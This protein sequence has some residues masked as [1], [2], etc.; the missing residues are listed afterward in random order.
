M[1]RSYAALAIVLIALIVGASAYGTYTLFYSSSPTPS[2]SPSPTPTASPQS[3]PTSS[4]TSTPTASPSASPTATATPSSTPTQTSTSPSP[5]NSPTPI[6]TT[7]PTST[8]TPTAEP[9]KTIVVTDVT[10]TQ[11]T[12]TLPVNRIVSLTS[13]LTELLCALGCEDKVVGRDSYSTFPPTVTQVPVVGDSSSDPNIELLLELEPDVVFADTML[14]YNPEAKAAIENAGVPV[15]LE[16][17]NNVTCLENCIQTLGEVLEKEATATEIIDFVTYY[18]N[19]VG[20]R[21]ENVT[22]SEKPAVYIEWGEWQSY[23]EGSGAHGNIVAAGGSNIA[24]GSASGYPTLSPEY[25]VEKNPDVILLLEFGASEKNMTSYQTSINTFLDRG[26]LDDTTAVIDGRVYSYS[27]TVFQGMRYPVGLLYF[28]KWFHPTLFADI[29][30]GAVHEELIQQFFGEPLN[31]TFAYPEIVTVVDGRGT[32]LTLSLPVERIVCLDGAVTMIISGLGGEDS[33]IGRGSYCIFPPSLLSKPDLGLCAYYA[34]VEQVLA[35][36]PDLIVLDTTID[37]NPTLLEQYQ[38]SGVPTMVELTS[39][40]EQISNLIE[41]FGFI[42][43]NQEKATALNDFLAHYENIVI[44]RVA[45]ITESE[46]PTVYIEWGYTWQSCSEGT[47]SN[48]HLVAAGGINIAADMTEDFPV[49]S[50]E[51]VAE[52]NPDIIL[53]MM[54]QEVIGNL[55]AFETARDELLSR[56]GLSDTNAA[57][58]GRVYLCTYEAFQGIRYPIGLLYFANWM[59]PDVFADVDPAVVH[60]DLIQQFFDVAL[61]GTYAYP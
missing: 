50:P 53:K 35:M 58:N 31:G 25:V 26:V 10:G 42:L 32:Q 8:P 48:G 34:S 23:A 52:Q 29:D 37:Y 33:V 55:T 56:P 49:L 9:K 47:S 61:E 22:D 36:E 46:K 45:N 13:G 6:P 27:P 12:V 14:S 17:M 44:D 15:V 18:K 51:F 40:S 38:N 2:P 21:L 54:E 24:S 19:L 28:A 30:P 3:S 1:K 7:T 16:L 4:P 59:H 11:V 41:N 43:D 57:K 20:E 5:T 60:A 39:N